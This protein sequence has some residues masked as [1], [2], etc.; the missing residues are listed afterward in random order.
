MRR[1]PDSH[2]KV[3]KINKTLVGSSPNHAFMVIQSVVVKS[4]HFGCNLITIVNNCTFLA[5]KS[6][7]SSEQIMHCS[8][9]ELRLCAN[10]TLRMDIRKYAS[11]PRFRLH[12]Y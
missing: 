7:T 11:I 2:I 9:R 1:Y 5:D 12:Q 8:R 3:Q 10:E 4:T 6:M